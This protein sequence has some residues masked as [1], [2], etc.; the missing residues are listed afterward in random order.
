VSVGG[1]DRP[2]HAL[3]QYLHIVEGTALVRERG[4]EVVSLHP[5][6]TIYPPPG[7]EH[8]HG[9]SPESFM[10]HLAIWEAPGDGGT[11]TAWGAPVTDEEYNQR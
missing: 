3:G 10:I 9:A 8:W 1:N 11:E 6:Q 2:C 5:G 7:V 4:G